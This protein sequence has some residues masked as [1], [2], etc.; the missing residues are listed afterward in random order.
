MKT[1]P[2][3]AAQTPRQLMRI[4]HYNVLQRHPQSEMASLRT[5]SHVAL[6]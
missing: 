3:E 2:I 1:T 6:P 5:L 4:Q